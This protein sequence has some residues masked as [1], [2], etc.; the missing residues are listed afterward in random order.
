MNDAHGHLEGDRALERLAA[1]LRE[2]T[3][4][5]NSVCARYGGEEFAVLLP[6]SDADRAQLIAERIRDV[7]ANEVQ[8]EKRGGHSLPTVSIG[9]ASTVP[10]DAIRAR[11]LFE[12]ADA[13]RYLAKTRGR[14]RYDVSDI[15]N[16]TAA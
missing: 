15:L 3:S 1:L 6:G 2:A 5:C 11:E 12:A 8:V 7:V 16:C 10:N 4:S 9:V 14:N 13:A